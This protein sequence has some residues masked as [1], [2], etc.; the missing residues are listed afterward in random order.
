MTKL[1]A[2]FTSYIKVALKHNAIDFYRSYK[3]NKEY[4]FISLEDKQVSVSLNWEAHTCFFGFE[5]DGIKNEKLKYAIS[6]LTNKQRKIFKLY[7]DG[8]KMKDI[9]DILNISITNVTVTIT[10]VKKK[11]IKLMKRK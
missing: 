1:Q 11:I 10:S 5:D 9:A 2:E 6:K 4:E 8:Y 3:R 7:V